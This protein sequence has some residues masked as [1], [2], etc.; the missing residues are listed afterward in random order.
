MKA[1]LSTL[2]L[3]LGI[4]LL[5]MS[6]TIRAQ[7][8]C[9]PASVECA[10]ASQVGIAVQDALRAANTSGLSGL[11]LKKAVLTLETVG[12]VTGGISINFLIFTIKHQSKKAN[13]I[14]QEITWGSLPKPNAV[15]GGLASL[16][17]V[18]PRAI[19]T[20]AQIASKVTAPA[21]SQAIITIKFVVDKDNG[22]SLSYKI[23]GLSLG[24]NVDLDK[25][26]T[27]T[28]AVTFVK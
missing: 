23:L 16:K 24:P 28:L 1:K 27:N 26:S 20:A 7:E 10:D 22:G 8:T 3:G 11:S 17:D 13:T 15:G 9:D 5:F 25:T 18:L 2:L 14:T 6:P 12:T 4:T 19:A 21:L